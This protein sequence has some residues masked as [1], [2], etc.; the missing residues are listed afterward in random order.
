VVGA[1]GGERARATVAGTLPGKIFEYLRAARPLLLLGD[2]AGDAAALLREHGR[3]WVAD[4]TRPA[5]IAAALQQMM[6]TVAD[7][8]TAPAPG[9]ARFERRALAGELAQFLR[10]CRQ[11]GLP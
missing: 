8:S 3:G 2:E 7:A 9:V 4:E 1:G 11:G 6:Q 5:A 10:R